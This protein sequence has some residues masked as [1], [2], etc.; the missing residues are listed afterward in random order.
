MRIQELELTSLIERLNDTN[1]DEDRLLALREL[2]NL[3]K[4]PDQEHAIYAANGIVAIAK[5]V[6]EGT[7]ANIQCSNSQMTYVAST[8]LAVSFWNNSTY[9]EKILETL[10]QNKNINNRPKTQLH[11]NLLND[12]AYD[13]ILER[14]LNK[15]MYKLRYSR[16][17]VQC[18]LHVRLLNSLLISRDHLLTSGSK[19]SFT[20]NIMNTLHHTVLLSEQSSIHG[21]AK[22]FFTRQ[23]SLWQDLQNMYQSLLKPKNQ[24][25]TTV[26][27]L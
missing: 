4:N 12:I 25:S 24:T 8:I 14:V 15:T 26:V 9:R 7:L 1:Q 16:S 22:R 5:I 11:L 17:E 21:M 18:L 27:I 6:R 2:H 13:S 19:I 3:S 23:N 20:K 10:I